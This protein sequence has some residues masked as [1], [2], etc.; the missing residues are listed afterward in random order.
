MLFSYRPTVRP[1]DW[2][3]NL[4]SCWSWSG[5]VLNQFKLCHNNLKVSFVCWN[6]KRYY[7]LFWV[8]IQQFL[9]AICKSYT[10]ILYRWWNTAPAIY[11]L[12]AQPYCI[13]LIDSLPNICTYLTVGKIFALALHPSLPPIQESTKSFIAIALYIK[14]MHAC[15]HKHPP[16]LS[17]E[18]Y[19]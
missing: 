13:I 6:W 9:H 1:T 14:C 16:A 15:T 2:L 8:W 4:C 7:T 12:V 10:Y 11:I 17:L 5:S 18:F 3:T 19:R